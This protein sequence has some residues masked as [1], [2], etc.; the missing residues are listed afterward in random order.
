MAK[1]GVAIS[2]GG[3]RATLFGLGVLLYLA[4]VARNN[5]VVTISSVSGGSITNAFV[6]RTDSDHARVRRR[7]REGRGVSG[8]GLGR[9]GTTTT[10]PHAIQWESSLRSLDR[11]DISRISSG[12]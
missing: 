8:T 5:E 7:T 4:D 10:R 3:H 12:P 2:G 1:I 9:M 6:T 11:R